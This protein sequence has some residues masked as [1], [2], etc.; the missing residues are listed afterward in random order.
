[1][2]IN[3]HIAIYIQ[4]VVC[5]GEDDGR[6]IFYQDVYRQDTALKNHLFGKD[7]KPD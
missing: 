6:I 3:K 2:P 1:M 7:F 5:E 4:N